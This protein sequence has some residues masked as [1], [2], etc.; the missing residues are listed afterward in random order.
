MQVSRAL[1]RATDRFFHWC[2]GCNDMH[3]LFYDRGWSFNG[4]LDKPSFT[5]SFKHSWGGKAV[6]HYV[7]TDGILHFCSDCSHGLKGQSVPLPELPDAFKDW[8]DG[9]MGVRPLN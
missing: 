7:L 5:P 6:C 3:P 9:N 8:D 1:R 4:S 2:P